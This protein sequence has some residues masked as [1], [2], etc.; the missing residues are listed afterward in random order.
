MDILGDASG[1]VSAGGLAGLMP[2]IALPEVHTA[3]GNGDVVK[4]EYVIMIG[5][6][7]NDPDTMLAHTESFHEGISLSE[8]KW[9]YVNTSNN[10]DSGLGA[11]EFTLHD[12]A[13][14]MLANF[15]RVRRGTNYIHFR[16]P[17]SNGKLNPVPD[18]TIYFPIPNDCKIEF[19]ATQGFTYTFVGHPIVQLSQQG[20]IASAGDFS[21]TGSQVDKTTT[22]KD[23]LNKVVVPMW[24]AQIDKGNHGNKTPT[25]IKEF[26]FVTDDYLSYEDNPA[27]TTLQETKSVQAHLEPFAVTLGMTVSSL[28]TGLFN[29]R[30]KKAEE[31]KDSPS[32]EVNFVKWK[33]EGHT[34]QV[35]FHDKK[36]QDVVSD[37]AVCIGDDVNCSWAEYR[38]QLVGIAFNDLVGQFSSVASGDISPSGDTTQG[39]NTKP[40][41]ENKNPVEVDPEGNKEAIERETSDYIS[42]PSGHGSTAMWGQLST[43]LQEQNIPS[44]TL[45]IELPY[46]FGFTPFTLGGK[47]KDSIEGGTGVGIHYTQGVQ[48][49][50]Y[51][52]KDPDCQTLVFRPEI[53]QA[54]RITSVSH[55][56]GL[57]GNTT[58]VGLSHLHIGKG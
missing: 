45:D 36:N 39:G 22:F 28:V 33:G 25:H 58:Q 57:N 34:I 31:Y 44:F 13:G 18:W 40:D 37:I 55:T 56:I 46:S 19:S 30:F 52:Y 7:D 32:L 51:W 50:F 2:V 47:L 4:M 26:V 16:G 29:E 42:M 14:G 38:A 10:A 21:I 24:N 1:M 54:Y 35:R 48:L 49:V 12:I 43:F 9:G 20:T 23:Y 3:V 17:M 41:P 53:S 15:I 27:Q 8:I 11:I 6:F 5:P